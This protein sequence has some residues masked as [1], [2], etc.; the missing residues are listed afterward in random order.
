MQ[1]LNLRAHLFEGQRAVHIALKDGLRFIAGFEPFHSHGGQGLP[2]LVQ[3]F[4]ALLIGDMESQRN[5]EPLFI[6]L[7]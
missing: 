6:I 1:G 5:N 2:H 3:T 7:A 4:E